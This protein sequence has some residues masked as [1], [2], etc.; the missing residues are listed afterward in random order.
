MFTFNYDWFLR[1]FINS[2]LLLSIVDHVEGNPQHIR[3]QYVHHGETIVESEADEESAQ[4]ELPET[5]SQ[6]SRNARQKT[7]DIGTDQRRYS[8]I[9]V[10][11]PSEDQAT[12]DRADE[13]NALG[14]RR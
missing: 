3:T 1:L 6:N 4:R 2:L 13:E 14:G 8:A 9:S 10:G 12:E 11:D 5:S 7:G